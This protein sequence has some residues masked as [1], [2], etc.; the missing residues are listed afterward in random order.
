MKEGWEIV[1][2]K[3]E[4]SLVPIQG[5]WFITM[6]ALFSADLRQECM[7]VVDLLQ[8]CCMILT[9]WGLGVA[10]IITVLPSSCLRGGFVG[11]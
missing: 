7:A 4:D 2:Y 3:G 5:S 10:V 1:K 6:S 11:L 9:L 8:L